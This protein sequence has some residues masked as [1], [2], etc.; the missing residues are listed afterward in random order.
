MTNEIVEQGFMLIFNDRTQLEITKQEKEMVEANIGNDYISLS[1]NIYRTFQFAKILSM[2]EFYKQYPHNRPFENPYDLT[3]EQLNF[4]I[5]SYSSN[6]ATEQIIKGLETYIDGRQYQGTQ[7]PIEML[8]KY[9]RKIY[10]KQTSK[11]GK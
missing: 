9:K 5:D 4:T 8:N 2:E 11:D 7:A 6:K 3:E 1:G 10:E